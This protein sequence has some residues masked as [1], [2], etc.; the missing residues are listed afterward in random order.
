M[1]AILRSEDDI[2]IMAFSDPLSP[3]DFSTLRLKIDQKIIQG[4]TYFVF[5]LTGLDVKNTRSLPSLQALV[6]FCLTRLTQPIIVLPDKKSWKKVVSQSGQRVEYFVKI[7][8]GL[9]FVRQIIAAAQKPQKQKADPRREDLER[10]IADY[11]KKLTPNSY[12]PLGLEKRAAKY[13]A[14]PSK[15][16]LKALEGAILQYKKL[17]AENEETNHE[18]SRLAEQVMSLTQLRKK[19]IRSDE[20][21]KRKSELMILQRL[22]EIEKEI[23]RIN[24]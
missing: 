7:D 14:D 4:R 13:K 17:K 18:V 10:L 23:L 11:K 20:I 12:D 15:D 24:N 9:T 5:D 2:Q 16:E 19:A 21:Q 3:E 6:D 1:P 22:A 8:D